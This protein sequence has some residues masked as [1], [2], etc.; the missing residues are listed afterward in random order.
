GCLQLFE[1]VR[2][3]STLNHRRGHTLFARSTSGNAWPWSITTER[4]RF[5][6]GTRYAKRSPRFHISTGN[7]AVVT[8]PS[9]NVIVS[10]AG[11]TIVPRLE[12][13]T[14]PVALTESTAWSNRA[15]V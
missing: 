12:R 13:W 15:V 11:I 3:L 9:S 5:R 8:L 6:S 14:A 2:H 10:C 1:N 7:L 4:T